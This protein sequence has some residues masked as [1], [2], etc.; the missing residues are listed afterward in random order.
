MSCERK[1][2]IPFASRC[3]GNEDERM[4]I[5]TVTVLTRDIK[6][7]ASAAR[8]VFRTVSDKDGLVLIAAPLHVYFHVPVPEMKPVD[9]SF[10]C[11]PV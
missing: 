11:P 2:L 3:S 5:I 4:I 8:D 7:H 6:T 1:G 10:I 9:E